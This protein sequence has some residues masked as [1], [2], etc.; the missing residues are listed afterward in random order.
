M[1]TGPECS[2]AS[3]KKPSSSSA[4]SYALGYRLSG[5]RSSVRMMIAS[6]CGG[7]SRRTKVGASIS[8][9]VRRFTTSCAGPLNR[10]RPTVISYSTTPSEKMSLR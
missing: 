2:R 1:R 3:R 5:C 10:R 4:R 9:S 6:S 7:K 8:P